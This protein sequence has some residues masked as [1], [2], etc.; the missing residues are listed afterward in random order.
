MLTR[1]TVII[2]AVLVSTTALAQEQPAFAP[3][4]RDLWESMQRAF[5]DISM[6]L[7]AHQQVISVMQQVAREAQ[8]REMRRKAAAEKSAPPAEPATK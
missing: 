7:P 8:M 1:Q 4:E 5:G 3:I 6:P 2:L